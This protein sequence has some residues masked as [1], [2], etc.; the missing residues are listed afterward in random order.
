MPKNN[1]QIVGYLGFAP[2]DPT[3]FPLISPPKYGKNSIAHNGDHIVKWDGNEWVPLVQ[4][5]FIRMVTN[6]DTDNAINRNTVFSSS[7]AFNG[8]TI[9]VDNGEYSPA[10]T[11]GITT[12]FSGFTTISYVFPQTST[13]AARGSLHTFVQR[14]RGGTLTQ[15]G[16]Q[17]S[18][19]RAASGSNEDATA[20]FDTVDCE[21]GDIFR[22]IYERGANTG[23]PINIIHEASL[24]LTRKI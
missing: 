17:Y 12:N 7:L 13:N 22:L 9:H 1:V 24:L 5:G 8:T 14:D 2:I 16:H 21:P 20:A 4:R 19:I 10:N 3:D 15:Y 11:N 6:G 23:N 18:Y